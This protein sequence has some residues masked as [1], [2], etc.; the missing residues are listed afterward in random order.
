MCAR[1]TGQLL[2]QR[3]SIPV[4][5]RCSSGAAERSRAGRR[6]RA[7]AR[8]QGRH[9][10]NALDIA[11]WRSSACT[12]WCRPVWR[13]A[14]IACRR[15][16]A[17]ARQGAAASGSRRAQLAATIAVAVRSSTPTS[18]LSGRP[19]RLASSSRLRLVAASKL[20][21][22]V[23]L[24]AAECHAGAASADF[25]VSRYVVEQASGGAHGQRLV[26]EAEAR[27]VARA[28]LLVS[29]RS[30]LPASNARRT[31]PDCARRAGAHD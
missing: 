23:A 9:A 18:V 25:S 7:A 2:E 20:Q 6:G 29:W 5:T 8:A 24:L 14:S 1:L 27:Q 30:A 3:E 12:A 13:N 17:R 28:E 4:S 31:V 16:L 21:R 26:C 19:E 11:D 15:W 10:Q 22:L